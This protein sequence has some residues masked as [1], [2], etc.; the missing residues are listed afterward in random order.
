L[1]GGGNP[2]YSSLATWETASD[3]DLSGTGVTILDCYDSQDHNDYIA[4]MAG[5]SNTDS[6]HYRVIRSSASCATPW[7]GKDGTGANFLHGASAD[8]FS[9]SESWARLVNIYLER[10]STDAS[11]RKTIYLMGTHSKV[12]GCVINSGDYCCGPKAIADANLFYACIV[13]NN[14]ITS[15]T[16]TTGSGETIGTICCTICPSNENYFN[17]IDSTSSDGTAIVFSCYSYE[18][19]GVGGCFSESNW[20]SPSGWNAADDATADLG[21]TAGDNY[22]NSIDYS[23]SLDANHLATAHISAN[24]N[25]GD[26]CGRNPYNDVTATTDFDDFLRN[27]TAGDPL[28]KYDIAGNE[29]PDEDVADAVWDVGAS[30]YVAS[31]G[32]TNNIKSV[33]GITWANVKSIGPTAKADIKKV[34]DLDTTS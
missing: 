25:A 9:I 12:I 8:T 16:I 13:Y 26:R 30:E 10:T 20:D 18:A 14:L 34:G 1:P 31:G 7:A 22:K 2:D 23:G 33:S 19:A 11:G 4:S 21:G 27:D 6:T 29:R 32:E 3:N 28:F 5:A 17:A 15:L 24:G